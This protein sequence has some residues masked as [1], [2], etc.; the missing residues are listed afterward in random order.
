M[1]SVAYLD[2]RPQP[3]LIRFV[4]FGADRPEDALG[5]E[6]SC[7]VD[8]AAE[9]LETG[10]PGYLDQGEVELVVVN[11]ESGERQT[12]TLDLA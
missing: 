3:V 12:F 9:F 6:A 10:A 7:A 8:A 1:G 11:A 5:L 2:I 4:V